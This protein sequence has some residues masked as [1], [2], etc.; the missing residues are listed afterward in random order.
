MIMPDRAPDTLQREE[1]G[2][3]PT[4][5]VITCTYNSARYLEQA[6]QSVLDQRYPKLDYWIIDGGSTDETLKII[7]KYEDRVSWISEPDCGI[8]DAMNKGIR[9][10]HGEIVAHLHSDDAYV[11]DALWRVGRIFQ[12]RADVK[13]IIG[14]YLE[15][16]EAGALIRT[17]TLPPYRYVLLKKWNMIGHPA[18][19]VRRMVFGEVGVFPL[20][21]RYG[22]DYDLWLRIGKRHEPLQLSDTLA[23][24]RVHAGG[25]TTR[26]LFGSL[27][28]GYAIRSQLE[29]RGVSA[30]VED[31]VRQAWRL[32]RYGLKVL[33][34]QL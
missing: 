29:G 10:S 28:E 30:R 22:M 26:E 20:H 27:M 34:R 19:F 2:P 7:G 13:W 31:V 32:L 23:C 33:C 4:I 18:A 15:I 14:N 11:N 21:L 25:L 12:Q 16:N 1:A 17:V 6:I 9:L 8:A 5:S 3:L 24:F